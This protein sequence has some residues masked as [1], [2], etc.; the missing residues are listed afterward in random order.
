MR[1]GPK[2][3]QAPLGDPKVKATGKSLQNLHMNRS[4]AMIAHIDCMSKSAIYHMYNS[5]SPYQR[6]DPTVLKSLQIIVIIKKM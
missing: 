5:F 1:W 3:G 2:I 4:E 6:I